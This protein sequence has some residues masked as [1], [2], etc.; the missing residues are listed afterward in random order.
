MWNGIREQ[1]SPT[2][3]A[4]AT[5]LVAFSVLL[6][7]ALELLRRRSE[8]L[9]AWGR[10]MSDIAAAATAVPGAPDE[11]IAC[12]VCD[13]LH[14]VPPIPANGR[15]TCR[16]CGNVLLLDPGTILDKILGGAFG[17]VVLVVSA[18]FFP[19]LQL[20]AKGFKSAASLVDTARAYR[21]GATAP[22][23]IALILLIVVLPVVRAS[24]LGYALL[25]M[26]LGR[27]LL[28][29]TRAAFHLATELRPWSMAEVFIVGVVV[30]LVKIGGMA[31]VSL[32]AGFWEMLL[33]VL[34]VILEGTT[35]NENTIWRMIDQK[36]RS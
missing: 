2:I 8:R 12:T 23:A 4:V 36:R 1:I 7:A 27:R 34:I 16:R 3:L 11:L 22:L 13:T 29:G 30:A 20:D 19:F 14:T 10:G 18:L 25:P 5:I 24:A 35:M 9:R 32:G 33:I 28:P 21:D 31:K 15:L 6:L 26:R 17:T